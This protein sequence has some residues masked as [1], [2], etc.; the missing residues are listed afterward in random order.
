MAAVLIGFITLSLNFY[1]LGED[2]YSMAFYT[3][4]RR[5]IMYGDIYYEC[6]VDD[7]IDQ[8][9]INHLS[10]DLLVPILAP[11][12]LMNYT[13]IQ[14]LTPSIQVHNVIYPE[15]IDVNVG[16]N[17][18]NPFLFYVYFGPSLGVLFALIIGFL[19]SKILF[20]CLLYTNR[21][22]FSLTIYIG[23]SLSAVYF[24]TDY[25]LGI[26]NMITVIFGYLFYKAIMMAV[27]PKYHKQ[28]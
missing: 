3:L 7:I 22:I 26:A 23:L 27:I 16:P 28:N 8:V 1:F 14:D 2:D 13:D 25:T 17:N 12:R 21:N 5:V 19:T 20:G 6:Y 15:L 11:F 24:V 4:F 9:T 18:R 10:N